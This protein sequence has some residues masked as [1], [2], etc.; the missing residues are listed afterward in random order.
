[1]V[2]DNNKQVCSSAITNILA[3]RY[4]P[5]EKTFIKKVITFDKIQGVDY[6]NKYLDFNSIVKRLLLYL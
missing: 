4:N 1:M 2:A 5:E 3:L 6:E